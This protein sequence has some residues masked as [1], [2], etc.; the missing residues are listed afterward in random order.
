MASRFYIKVQ[1]EAEVIFEG[2][3]NVFKNTYYKPAESVNWTDEDVLEC[4]RTW[5]EDNNW[6]FESQDCH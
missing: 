6:N 4:A 2:P 1:S 5:A 3:L